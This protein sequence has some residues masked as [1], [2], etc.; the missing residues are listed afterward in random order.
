MII[1]R[2]RPSLVSV[3]NH[4]CLKQGRLPGASLK[5]KE[6][7]FLT[8]KMS[9]KSLLLF[10]KCFCLPLNITKSNMPYLYSTYC[11]YV[12]MSEWQIG[13][14]CKFD[15]ISYPYGKEIKHLGTL[16]R[17]NRFNTTQIYP[18]FF[19]LTITTNNYQ[20]PSGCH[21]ML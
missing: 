18:L 12:P 1:K 11:K 2:G 8:R 21:P 6:A 17:R 16:C 15:D 14:N 9:V 19:K 5:G 7:T 13:K 4:S 10:A 20:K 3:K